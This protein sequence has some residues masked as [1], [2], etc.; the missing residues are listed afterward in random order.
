MFSFR[1]A[2]STMDTVNGASPPLSL[3]P[4]EPSRHYLEADA[5]RMGHLVP[6]CAQHLEVAYLAC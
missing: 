3:F 6:V 2:P 5:E 4:K 1:E